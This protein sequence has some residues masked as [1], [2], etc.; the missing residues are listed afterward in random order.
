MQLHESNDGGTLLFNVAHWMF[1][2]M[3]VV[4]LNVK[5]KP[6]S[7][8]VKELICRQMIEVAGNTFLFTH[9]LLVKCAFIHLCIRHQ[10]RFPICCERQMLFFSIFW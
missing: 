4:P 2:H 6:C 8:R 5:V 1:S 10:C 7:E 9:M 3:V